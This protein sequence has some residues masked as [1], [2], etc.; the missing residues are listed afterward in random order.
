MLDLIPDE[1]P[2]HIVAVSSPGIVFGLA[3]EDYLGK[4][5]YVSRLSIFYVMLLCYVMLCY[6]SL[7]RVCERENEQ[8]SSRGRGRSGSSLSGEPD[9][10]PGS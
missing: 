2:G 10:G 7:E 9:A 1:L 6:V 5:I 4:S 8:E 3:I